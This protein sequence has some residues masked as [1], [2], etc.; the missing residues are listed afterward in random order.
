M[1]YS[2]GMF[3]VC[4]AQE[5]SVSAQKKAYDCKHRSS[6]LLCVFF[7]LACRT[8]MRIYSTYVHTIDRADFDPPDFFFLLIY[9]NRVFNRGSL[10]GNIMLIV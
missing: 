2:S 4:A 10:Y 5:K 1:T 9:C 3:H 6:R 8:Y 7:G